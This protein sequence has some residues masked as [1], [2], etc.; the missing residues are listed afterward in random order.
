MFKTAQSNWEDHA[1]TYG[2]VE[3]FYSSGH[4]LPAG[5]LAD[6]EPEGAEDDPPGRAAAAA[7]DSE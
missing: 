2:L 5:G 7:R 4:A 1:G 3:E 6:W